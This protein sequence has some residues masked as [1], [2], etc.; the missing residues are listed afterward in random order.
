M[1]RVFNKIQPKIIGW[2]F[3]SID[4]FKIALLLLILLKRFDCSLEIAVLVMQVSFSLE[5]EL[6]LKTIVISTG[7]FFFFLKMKKYNK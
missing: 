6:S 4:F 1:L 2:N 3:P 7:L 5:F